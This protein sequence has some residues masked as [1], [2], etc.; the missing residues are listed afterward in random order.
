MGSVCPAALCRCHGQRVPARWR[1]AVFTHS[2]GVCG[3]ELTRDVDA[4]YS[5][6]THTHRTYAYTEVEAK[7]EV[8]V[9]VEAEAEA[10]AD[11]LHESDATGA[12]SQPVRNPNR[13][14]LPIGADSQ[15]V[16]N[17][18]RC[19]APK[20]EY[21]LMKTNRTLVSSLVPTPL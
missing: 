17:P 12:E 5:G 13:C 2:V 21:L 15:S 14:G 3:E 8:K 18:N 9:E 19:G 11:A 20:G 16:R 1:H 10:E 4:L 7:A 6:S